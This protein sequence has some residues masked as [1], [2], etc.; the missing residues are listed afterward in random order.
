[1]TINTN[2]EKME[3]NEYDEKKEVLI[4]NNTLGPQRLDSL[5][6]YGFNWGAVGHASDGRL[7]MIAW[8]HESGP[9]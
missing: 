4:I 2:M 8:V 5:Q 6:D 1:M 3:D 7:L 9:W